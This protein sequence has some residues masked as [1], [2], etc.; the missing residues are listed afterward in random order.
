MAKAGGCCQSHEISYFF[1]ILGDANVFFFYLFFIF[2]LSNSTYF[3]MGN[4]EPIWKGC[5]GTGPGF[6]SCVAPFLMSIASFCIPKEMTW[7]NFLLK[8]SC[9][10]PCPWC[11]CPAGTGV[12]G[13]DVVRSIPKGAQRLRVT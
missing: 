6:V 11:P 4:G 9:E 7:V 10:I 1:Q 12:Q 5:Q 2:P 3:Q 8:L 13:A